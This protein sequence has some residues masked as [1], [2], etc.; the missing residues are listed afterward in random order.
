M[1][2]FSSYTL[3]QHDITT[4]EQDNPPCDKTIKE[5]HSWLKRGTATSIWS[6]SSFS[7]LRLGEDAA[8][9][10]RDATKQLGVYRHY[11]THFHWVVMLGDDL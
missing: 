11:G 10:Q 3:Q 2:N 8:A 6:R 4:L 7:T 5:T 9:E 1:G